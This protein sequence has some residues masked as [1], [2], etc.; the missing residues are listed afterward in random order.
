V[1]A[2]RRSRAAAHEMLA[3]IALARHDE[4][5][6]LEEAALAREADPSLPLPQYVEARL[7]YDQG[8]YADALPIFQDALAELK[9]AKAPPMTELHFY[10]GD[11]FGRLERYAEAETEFIQ[12]LKF[13]PQNT[14]ARGGLAML[15]EA[16]GKTDEAAHVLAEMMRVT[17][18][19]DAYALAVRLHTMFGHRQQAEQIRADARKAFGGAGAVKSRASR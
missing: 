3:K 6:A 10:L 1:P 7:L 18:T 4:T 11:T 9:Q 2:D 12:E 13:F 14:R 15:Y 19:P 8:R 16:S 5:T 17:P